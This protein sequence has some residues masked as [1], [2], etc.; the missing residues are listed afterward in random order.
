MFAF[1][2]QVVQTEHLDWV[3]AVQATAMSLDHLLRAVFLAYNALGT[4]SVMTKILFDTLRAYGEI[5]LLSRG[6]VCVRARARVCV[7]GVFCLV[8][9]CACVH[10]AT[11]RLAGLHAAPSCRAAL[12]SPYSRKTSRTALLSLRIFLSTAFLALFLFAV[13]SCV[14]PAIQQQSAM[15]QRSQKDA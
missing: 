2:L 6:G 11:G 10:R 1:L 5:D 7:L 12:I 4:P 3:G 14:C 9:V 13:T 8:C 15:L